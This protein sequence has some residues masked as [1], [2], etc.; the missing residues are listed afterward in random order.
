[1]QDV[2]AAIV[3]LERDMVQLGLKGAMIND[4]VNVRTFNEPAF[5]P[6]WKADAQRNW[7]QLQHTVPA[8]NRQCRGQHTG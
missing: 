2:P 5:F 1:M 8:L 6:F 3:K 4:Y 7:C